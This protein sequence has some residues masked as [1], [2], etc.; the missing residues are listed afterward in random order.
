MWISWMGHIAML[1]GCLLGN[2]CLGIE[3]PIIVLLII[4]LITAEFVVTALK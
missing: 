3:L 4:L 1:M 2:N